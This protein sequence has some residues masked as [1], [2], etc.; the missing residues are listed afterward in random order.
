MKTAKPPIFLLA[1][2]STTAIQ[3]Y[4]GGGWGPG[5]LTTLIKGAIGTNYGHNGATTVS[6]VECGDWKRIMNAVDENGDNYSP[7]VTIQVSTGTFDSAL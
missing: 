6:F 5:F 1:G 4:E 7:Y 2:D 3:S